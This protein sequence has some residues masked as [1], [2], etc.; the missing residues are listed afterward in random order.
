MVHELQAP[1]LPTP[2]ALTVIILPPALQ[3]SS[4]NPPITL[5][6]CCSVSHIPDLLMSPSFSLL[7]QVIFRPSPTSHERVTCLLGYYHPPDHWLL[8][9]LASS[10]SF[11]LPLPFSIHRITKLGNIFH[12][13]TPIFPV[14]LD[15]G[16]A[17]VLPEKFL[18]MLPASSFSLLQSTLQTMPRLFGR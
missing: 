7:S 1:G 10:I 4:D 18:S 9:Q 14:T 2:P 8:S 3:L 11:A 5:L 6:S 17:I 15:S 12:R 16:I 13:S